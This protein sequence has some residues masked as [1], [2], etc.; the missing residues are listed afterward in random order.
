VFPAAAVLLGLLGLKVTYRQNLFAGLDRAVDRLE[1]IAQPGDVLVFCSEGK[2]DWYSG[3][4]LA[5]AYYGGSYPRPIVILD[6]PANEALLAQFHS[7]GGVTAW[8]A[9]EDPTRFFPGYVLT[10]RR[11]VFPHG[12]LGRFERDVETTRLMVPPAMPG[13]KDGSPLDAGA[14]A[15][16]DVH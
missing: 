13:A 5:W 6:S 16:E 10:Q 14:A 1:A 2:P 8:I 3:H 9:D 12:L 4:Y 15:F 11:L 7:H